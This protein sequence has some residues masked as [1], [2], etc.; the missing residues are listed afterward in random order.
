[1]NFLEANRVELR[2]T[3]S[4][5]NGVL[6]SDLEPM[7]SCQLECDIDFKNI[8]NRS[9]NVNEGRLPGLEAIWDEE[10]RRCKN[11]QEVLKLKGIASQERPDMPSTEMEEYWMKRLFDGLNKLNITL[12][13]NSNTSE[14]FNAEQVM[15]SSDHE[16]NDCISQ[17]IEHV[18]NNSQSISINQT[19][20]DVI[21]NSQN[22]ISQTIE[23]V[24]SESQKQKKHTKVK[25]NPKKGHNSRKR[26]NF[27][28][29]VVEG[30]SRGTRNINRETDTKE[31]VVSDETK[32]NENSLY[33]DAGT[34]TEPLNSCDDSMDSVFGLEEA[35]GDIICDCDSDECCDQCCDRGS[36]Q[37]ECD[38][39]RCEFEK[40]KRIPQ[41]D[42][43]F[44][45][46]DSDVDKDFS[47]KYKD[48][49]DDSD[50]DVGSKKKKAT[51]KKGAKRGRG[52]RS[53]PVKKSRAASDSEDD[54]ADTY[55]SS[56]KRRT[57]ARAKARKSPTPEKSDDD[58]IFQSSSGRKVKPSKNLSESLWDHFKPKDAKKRRNSGSPLRVSFS[59]SD[60]S[61]KEPGF[62]SSFKDFSY[63]P[64]KNDDRSRRSLTP[65][66][67]EEPDEDK[68]S[69]TKPGPRS[70]KVAAGARPGPKSSK[71]APAPASRPGPKSSKKAAKPGP[72]SSKRLSSLSSDDIEIL[73]TSTVSRSRGRG[74]ARSTIYDEPIETKKK[75]ISKGRGKRSGPK[76]KC[77]H[78]KI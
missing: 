39:E 27:T 57:T 49:S 67:D 75:A 23:D 59:E 30:T 44:D 8:V 19:I 26:L 48:D 76:P 11:S 45:S 7:S 41:M 56:P 33:V 61:D 37:C 1:M 58:D 20:E 3:D 10:L 71:A 43:A 12:D 69:K 34:Q 47:P 46:D 9:V 74:N 13:V 52:K 2:K 38:C 36:D 64:T 53:T 14:E 5:P 55:K 42:G 4:L 62:L 21:I 70:A 77:K 16:S 24:V 54:F 31:G 6:Y 40:C 17:T 66:L 60:G 22:N 35:I 63:T 78:Q 65:Y 72:K 50:Y 68:P 28:N 51:P 73:E 25:H 29:S 15:D 18:I 32:S